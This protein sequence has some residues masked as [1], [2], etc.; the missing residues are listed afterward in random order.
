MSAAPSNLPALATSRPFIAPRMSVGM[1]VAIAFLALTG[2]LIVAGVM[3]T[4]SEIMHRL[5]H[6]DQVQTAPA[7]GIQQATQ[8]AISAVANT[9]PHAYPVPEK[10]LQAVL[11][12]PAGAVVQQLVPYQ[13]GVYLLVNVPREGQRILI[14]D[15]R[16]GTVRQ[17]IRV[18]RGGK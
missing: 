6:A 18:Q 13:E 7:P 9:A 17:D 15:A 8:Q 2:I 4:L 16:N 11:D 5:D 10:N 12:L 14:L 3:M 1:K